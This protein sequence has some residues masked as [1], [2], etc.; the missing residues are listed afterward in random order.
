METRNPDLL[1]AIMRLDNCQLIHKQNYENLKSQ[2][3]ENRYVNL[4][5]GDG[6][7]MLVANIIPKMH[8]DLQSIKEATEF[9]VDFSKLHKIF[10]KYYIYWITVVTFSGW[11]IG[12][13]VFQILKDLIK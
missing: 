2:I 7:R 5:N 10:K 11:Q 6:K 8:N 13:P 12:S 4:Q 3:E 9:L 1:D